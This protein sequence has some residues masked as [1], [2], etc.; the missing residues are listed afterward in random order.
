[1]TPRPP[2]DELLALFR[3]TVAAEGVTTGAGDATGDTFIDAALIGAGDNS[4]VSM[5]A[6]LYP[7]DPLK[8][9]SKDITAFNTAT[10]EVTLAGAYKGAPG[11]I[12]A[13]APY[14]IVTFRFVPAEVAAIA[15]ALGTHD[16]DI[17][18]LLATIAGYI[19]DEV[20]AIIASQARQ[21]FPM[22]FWSDPIEEISLTQAAGTL[23]AVLAAWDVTIENL[24]IGATI[25][26]AVAMLKFRMV[27]NNNA[28]VNS[29]DG[30]TDPD[31]SQVIQVE[32]DA[33][34][35]WRDAINFVDDQ[36]SLAATTRESGDVCIGTINIAVEV[37][38]NDTY[39]LQW[40]LSKANQDNL[41]FN[42]VQTGLRIWYSV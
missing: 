20:A 10:G 17:K 6:I 26:R 3:A 29:L 2:L 32:T 35:T 18:A 15:A 41:N 37:T 27:E 31:T 36:F 4:F 9:D 39:H 7:G 33:P 22:D 5:L 8:V 13:G 11:A 28:A 19:D 14:T 24:P 40:L 38:G 30:A 1:M 42:D 12:P 16:T 23:P 25:V 34:G 21:L